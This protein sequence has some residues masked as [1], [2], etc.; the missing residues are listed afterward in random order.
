MIDNLIA[1]LQK[2]G[3]EVSHFS[4]NEEVTQKIYELIPEG[5][6]VMTMSS[7][8]L[9]ELGVSKQINESGK[10]DAVKPKLYSG[11]STAICAASMPQF[12][13]GSVQAITESGELLS[14]S[15]TGSQIPAYVYGAKKVIFVVSTKK[16][17]TDLNSA[18][19]RISDVVA[20][21]EDQRALKAYG[22]HTSINKILLYNK[23]HIAGRT[24]V[25][26]LDQPIGY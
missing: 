4:T 5:S 18:L 22:V 16:I 2:N 12:A 20:P 6:Q 15:A 19:K 17:V 21:L 7:V 13:I 26:L 14:V 9:D 25:I 3:F 24:H 10:Y 8:T 11:E 1:N 23:E